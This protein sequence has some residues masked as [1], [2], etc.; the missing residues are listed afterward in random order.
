MQSKRDANCAHCSAFIPR[1]EWCDFVEMA[2]NKWREICAQCSES[3]QVDTMELDAERRLADA[4]NRE[5]Q[6]GVADAKRYQSD[7]AIYG[8]TLAEQWELERE[9]RNFGEDI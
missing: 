7:R 2:P 6:Q 3:L 5:Y 8:E 1:G 9:I 4:E